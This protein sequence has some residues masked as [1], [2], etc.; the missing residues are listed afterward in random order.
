MEWLPV[1]IA[2]ILIIFFVIVSR[3]YAHER[4][5]RSQ[6]WGSY[7]GDDTA[8][9]AINSQGDT[10]RVELPPGVKPEDVKA[11]YVGKKTEKAKVTIRHAKTNRRNINSNPDTSRGM[12][13][14]ASDR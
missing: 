14:R 2:C 11:V 12:G 5:E 6:K 3:V 4:K 10:V 9:V 1:Y 7:P 13:L 8:V